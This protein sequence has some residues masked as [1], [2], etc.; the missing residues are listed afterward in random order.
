MAT[1]PSV[2]PAADAPRQPWLHTMLVATD[3][4][5]TLVADPDGDLRADR[6]ARAVCGW[7]VDDRRILSRADLLLD[8]VPAVPVASATRGARVEV[9]GAARHL[10]DTGADP[11]VEV[12]RRRT[13]VGTVGSLD[14]TLTERVTLVS[15]AAEPVRTRLRLHLAGDG[16]DVEQVKGGLSEGALL[17]ADGSG[18]L[19][20]RHGVRVEAAGEGDLTPVVEPV[21]GGGVLVHADIDLPAR[22]AAELTVT[23]TA[24]RLARTTFDADAGSAAAPWRGVVVRS[25]DPRLAPLVRT[26]L[27][28]LTGLLQRDPQAPEDVYL[29]AGTPWYLTLFGRDSLWSARLVLPFAPE[30]AGGTLRALARR[31]GST[32]D[33]ATAEEPGRILHE[34]RRA[35]VDADGTAD[36]TGMFLPPVYYGTIDATALWVLTLAEAR[37]WG[38]PRAQV[39]ELLPTLGRALGWLRS[40]SARSG[41]G[42]LR[43][44]D[45]TGAGLANQGWKDSGDSMRHRDGRIALAPIALLE[46]QGYAVEAAREAAGLVRALD[47]TPQERADLGSDGADLDTDA[48]EAWAGRL[49]DAVHAQFWVDGE[50]GGRRYLAMAIA[51]DGS[52]VDGVGSNMGHVL[53]GSLLDDAAAADV[54][55]RMDADLLGPF[56][57][58]TLGRANPAYNPLGY[59]TGSVWTH[60]NAIILLGLA[61]RGRSAQAADLAARLVASGSAFEGRWPELCG[62]DAVLGRPVPYPASCRP[63]AWS[64]ASAGGLLRALLGLDADVPAGELQVDPAAAGAFLPLAVR[65]LRVGADVVDVEVDAPL[66]DAAPRVRVTGTTLRVVTRLTRRGGVRA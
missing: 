8:E 5:T 36:G 52:L 66:G 60:D 46:A 47:L 13:V 29:A 11:T 22:A 51:G 32:V 3:G 42:L 54:A 37:R 50:D 49:A 12:H 26:G 63:Q 7:F 58:G 4:N 61:E 6:P 35:V 39:I 28:D 21:T 20:S 1:A 65:G 19:D 48:W 17:V 64:A 40:A 38:L 31:Q 25:G 23:V 45:E 2:R 43:Y 10:G 24:H 57:L 62:G 30:L 55:E 27:A 9:L 15:R 56:G 44:V 14:A 34:V 16:H 41:D 18:W 33:P 53:T 59:H